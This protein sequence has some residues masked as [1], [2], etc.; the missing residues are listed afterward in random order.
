M[1]VVALD[2]SHARGSVA[3][4]RGGD[5]LASDRFGEGVSHLVGLG[6]TV[7]TLLEAHSLSPRDIDRVAL[8]A[9]PGSFTGLRIALAWVKGLHAAL[10]MDVVTVGTLELLALPFLHETSP[11]CAMIDARR[12]E[13]YGALYRARNGSDAT[14]C[15]MAEEV[16][17][18]VASDPE[19]FLASVCGE[20]A[21]FVGTGA[22]AYHSLL[23]VPARSGARC[24]IDEPDVFPS[25]PYLAGVAHHLEPLAHD[26]IAALE[27]VYLRAA[28]ARR[29]RLGPLRP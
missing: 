22:A 27:P 9:G 15:V 5:L 25:T 24:I 23:E 17:A 14:Q 28:G 2:A 10:G 21:L 26:R 3:L 19:Q 6:Q 12:R 1:V 20:T 7:D 16:I 4:A 18:P 29:T 13:V 11:V 8:V